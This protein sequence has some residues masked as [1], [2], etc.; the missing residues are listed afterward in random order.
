MSYSRLLIIAGYIFFMLTAVV[1]ER[2]PAVI[3]L[4][5]PVAMLTG[6]VI[7]RIHSGTARA[8]QVRTAKQDTP[9]S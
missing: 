4:A 3:V 8:Q 5:G 2:L 6:I 7:A 9:S 1:G